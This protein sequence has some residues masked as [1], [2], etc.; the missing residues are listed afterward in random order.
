MFVKNHLG[1]QKQLQ[2]R[3]LVGILQLLSNIIEICKVLF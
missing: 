1:T 3:T 2:L